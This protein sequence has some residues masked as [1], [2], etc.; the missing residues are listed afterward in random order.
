[1][2]ITLDGR[3]LNE[4]DVDA[5]LMISGDTAMAHTLEGAGFKRKPVR[6]PRGL[7]NGDLVLRCVWEK[8]DGNLKVVVRSTITLE[9]AGLA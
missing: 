4:H 5:L 6:A 1:M 9:A 8:R 7:R 2:K 3:R